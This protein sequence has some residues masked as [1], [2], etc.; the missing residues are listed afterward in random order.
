M[1]RRCCDDRS[2]PPAVPGSVFTCRR[3]HCGGMR[4]SGREAWCHQLSHHAV[5][6]RRDRVDRRETWPD[7]GFRGAGRLSVWCP[8]TAG[9]MDAWHPVGRI[10]QSGTSLVLGHAMS[11]FQLLEW[12]CGGDV[13]E[14]DSRRPCGEVRERELD[15]VYSRAGLP[16]VEL[17]C[18][19]TPK[20]IETN[21]GV[22]WA[23][24]SSASVRL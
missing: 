8:T 5:A 13:P 12:T 22:G 15:G 20:R 18:A 11:T 7:G 17:V 9:L 2:N 16:Y 19:R 10:F 21:L 1:N 14:P 24:C 3:Q 4:G 23:G 6:L